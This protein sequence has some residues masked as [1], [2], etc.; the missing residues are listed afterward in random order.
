MEHTA[1]KMF[2]PC[3]VVEFDAGIGLYLV[4]DIGVLTV[5]SVQ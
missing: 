5:H 3:A 1:G 2:F 4:D